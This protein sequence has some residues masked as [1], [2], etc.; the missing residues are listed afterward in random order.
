VIAAIGDMPP[1]TLG[2]RFVGEVTGDDYRRVLEPA[3]EDAVERGEQLR[4]LIHF[5]TAVGDLGPGALGED[6]R[7]GWTM[8]VRHRAAW[9]RTALVSDADWL[10]RAG[11]ALA[12]LAP[13]ELRVFASEAWDEARSWVAGGG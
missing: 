13:G 4:V 9:E 1:G 12:W 6:L 3:L 8:G 11:A 2:F 7:T 10:R 5:D